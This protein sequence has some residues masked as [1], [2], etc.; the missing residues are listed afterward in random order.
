MTSQ[1]MPFAL[2]LGAVSFVL[3]VIWGPPLI[4]LLRR[5]KV[6][7]QIRV[8]LPSDHQTKMGTPTMGGLM[9]LVPVMIIAVAM[10]LANFLS[11]FDAGKAL[12]TL[13]NFEQGS[14]LIGKSIL[15]PLLVLASFGVLGAID[16]LSEVRGWWGGEGLRARVMFPLQVL[17]AFAAAIGLYHS[18]FL[19]LSEVGIPGVSDL[20]DVGIWYVPIATI[21]IVAMANAVNLTDGLDG[22]ASSI[23]AVVFTA[24][25]IV[26]FLQTQ[27][28]LLSFCFT[29]VGALFAFLWFNAYPA[30][31]FMGGMGALAL[32]ATIAVVA[33][34]SFQWILLPII[35]LIFVAEAG[36]VVIQV[37]YFKLSRRLTGI[38]QR[39]FKMTPLHLH[40][41]LLGWSETQVT[42]RFWIIGVLAAMLGIALALL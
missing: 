24:Y 39:V 3:A 26:A 30:A 11:G 18:R 35:A 5:W 15:L 4:R 32:G 41:Q 12:L 23:A 10:N 40:F 34:M 28:P 22:L 16:D 31:L 8:E 25:G 29:L 6:G 17:L 19:G 7:K 36:S 13:F 27:Y 38:G 21:T 33:L 37:S 1:P 2:A 14:P 9:I 42:Q 20:V